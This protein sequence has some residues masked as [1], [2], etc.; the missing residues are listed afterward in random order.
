MTKRDRVAEQAISACRPRR[1]SE[2]VSSHPTGSLSLAGLGHKQKSAR[3]IETERRS[4]NELR[5][6]V[7]KFDAKI[8]RR[9]NYIIFQTAEAAPW[10][11]HRRRP[12][13]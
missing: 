8:V 6:Q 13:D 3:P 7:S 12:G 1:Q 9:G 5:K 11:I 10:S 2:Q 4:I